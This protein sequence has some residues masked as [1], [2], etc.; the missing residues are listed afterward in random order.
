MSRIFISYDRDDRPFT[1]QLAQRLRRIYDHVWFDEN[2]TGGVDWWNEIRAQIAGCEIFMYLLTDQSLRSPY[3]QAEYAEATRLN[4]PVLP[5]RIGP[6]SNV[7]E[8][9]A[10]IQYVDM[11]D[12][13]INVENLTE[14]NA[15]IK[16]L[17]DRIMREKYVTRV[18]VRSRHGAVWLALVIALLLVALVAGVVIAA[19]APPFEGQILFTR[20][21][22]IYSIEGGMRGRLAGIFGGNPRPLVNGVAAES[23]LAWSPD[24]TR[25]AFTSTLGGSQDIY[26]MN[27]DGSD[28]RAL[29]SDP[30]DDIH[31]AWS[32]DGAQIAFASNRDGDYD[33]YAIPANCQPDREGC[34]VFP[35]TANDVD[36]QWPAWSPNNVIA[37]A[38]LRT[39][40]WDI[41]T[42]NPAQVNAGETN[43]TNCRTADEQSPVWSPDGS[44]IAFMSNRARLGP[45][46]VPGGCGTARNP[47][48]LNWDIYVINVD[49][50]DLDP[51]TSSPVPDLY[52]AWSPTNDWL[53][54]VSVDRDGSNNLYVVNVNEPGEDIEIV[55]D[56]DG[57]DFP[58]WRP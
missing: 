44:S 50:N 25:V 58:A 35:L 39:S 5:V 42:L 11:S 40:N 7:P 26:V 57:I 45:G 12:G 22:D 20:G 24:G 6:V 14:L 23:P 3:C 31:P 2:L 49:D 55:D 32:P 1:R 48:P 21:A 18:T 30:A 54:F 4:K 46:S 38:S 53:V 51:V 43:L 56:L 15:A 33:L 28:L 8:S 13:G 41:Y 34:D 10:Q 16:K 29:T 19:P 27:A 37:F 9:L 52:P 17:S 36:D 47:N